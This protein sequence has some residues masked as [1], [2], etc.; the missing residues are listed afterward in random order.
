[1][2]EQDY[3]RRSQRPQK[4]RLRKGRAFF[5]LLLL[6]VIVIAGYSV[7]QYRSG[8]K[9]AS[10]TKV[11][12]EDFKGDTV[13]GDVENYLLLGIDTRGEEKSRTDTMMVLSWN[14]KTNDM[15]LVSLMRDIYADIPGY[16]SYKLNT[17]YYL[18]G[19]QLL[20]DTIT[21]MFGLPIHHY[22]IIDF[23]N[24]ESLVDILAPNGVEMDVDKDMSENIG[25]SLK[26]GVHNLNGQELLGFARFRHD[27]EG[28]FGRVARQQKVI[29]ALKNE[30]LSPQNMVNLPKFVG[31]AQGY[32]TTDYSSAEEVQQVLKMVSKGKVNIEKATV[33]I[34]GSY[35][36]QSFRG[37]GDSIVM[38][39]EKNKE[40]LRKFLG[41]PLE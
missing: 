6:F 10:D 3:S 24:F 38:D 27:A 30:V 20:K 23:K 8:L 40:F 37:V 13:S 28:D 29:E 26:Q 18:D 17:A 35:N 14:K 31:A 39:V 1:M 15:K 25:V 32:I 5:T 36:F 16:K 21:N 34:E 12:Q 11:A 7:M 41:I 22:A 2:E 19:V 33:P 9:L 4:R